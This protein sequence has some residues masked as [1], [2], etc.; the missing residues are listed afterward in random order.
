LALGHTHLANLLSDLN[1]QKEA[2]AH[3]HAALEILKPLATVFPEVPDY[4]NDLGGALGR[5]AGV[6]NQQREF[7]LALALLKQA[8]PYHQAALNA[9]SRH[10]AYRLNY[11]TTLWNL[12][13]SFQGLADHA[14]LAAAAD[15]LFQLAHSQIDPWF[16]L[17]WLCQAMSLVDKDTLL[18]ADRRK[19]LTRT[20]GD[21]AL[22]VLPVAVELGAIDAA[23]MKK[24]PILDPLRGRE[25][26]KKLL[27]ELESKQKK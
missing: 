23:G 6:H 24:S 22:A 5:L 18:A 20:Y 3:Y 2:G 1:Q 4:Q 21:R 26:F 11:R 19:E 15:D 27:D 13:Q 8:R 7:A 25:E 16:A 14:G 10:P 17:C 12:G 9:S